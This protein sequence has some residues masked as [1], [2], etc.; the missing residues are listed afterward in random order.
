MDDSRQLFVLGLLLGLLV[1]GATGV[2]LLAPAERTTSPSFSTASVTGCVPDAA[3]AAWIGQVP[4]DEGQLVAF[5]ATVLHDTPD[6]DL[7]ANLSE[8]SPGRFQFALVPTR[9]DSERKGDP[10]ADC[11]PRTTLDA[12]ISLPADYEMLTIVLGESVVTRVENPD[13]SV[14]TFRTLPGNYS[15][16]LR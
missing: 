14:A 1:G 2:T 15:A 4:T 6:L 5:N 10:P 12:T 7:R 9:G 13:T 8:P 11:Q 16:S 3:S